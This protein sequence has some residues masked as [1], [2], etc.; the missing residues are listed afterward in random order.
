MTLLLASNIRVPYL[1]LENNRNVQ[2][3]RTNALLSGAG[4][5]TIP[6]TYLIGQVADRYSFARVMIGGSLTPLAGAFITLA[7][8]RSRKLTGLG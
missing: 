2:E 6:A 3:S 7:L 5:R 1:L 4:L 8:T